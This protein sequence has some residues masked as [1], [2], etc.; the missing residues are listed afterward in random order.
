MIHIETEG[1]GM[2][3]V[4][5]CRDVEMQEQTVGLYT[6]LVVSSGDSKRLGS[7]LVRGNVVSSEREVTGGVGG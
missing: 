7:K 1:I 5:G 2:A 6:S 4:G 3:I